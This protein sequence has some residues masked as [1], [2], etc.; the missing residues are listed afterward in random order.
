MHQRERTNVTIFT[1]MSMGNS[2][3]LG[4]AFYIRSD[5]AQIKQ[6]GCIK[7][8]GKSTYQAEMITIGKAL[9]Y[10]KDAHKNYE[11]NKVY[12]YCDNQ[13]CIDTLTA[14]SLRLWL[15]QKPKFYNEFNQRLKLFLDSLGLVLEGRKVKAH[16]SGK[17]VRTSVNNWMDGEARRAR[18]IHEN[19]LGGYEK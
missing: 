5:Y 16:T 9:K 1:D 2:G 4:W 7:F 11:I 13:D 8:E 3:L 15:F 6:A 12:I 14:Y 10:M 18:K 17:C 19:K